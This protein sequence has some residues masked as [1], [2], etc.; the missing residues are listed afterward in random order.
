VA[1]RG[2]RH[3][4]D[5]RRTGVVEDR[6]DQPP[7]DAAAHPVGV[8]GE[9]LQVEVAVDPADEREPGRGL[10]LDQHHV[11]V[12]DPLDHGRA[13]RE[14][15]AHLL[16]QLVGGELH[17]H[18]AGEIGRFSPSHHADTISR[19]RDEPPPDIRVDDRRLGCA[20]P[21]PPPPSCP[22]TSARGGGHAGLEVAQRS[23][24][25]SSPTV[26]PGS[27]P[28]RRT[29]SSTPGVNAARFIVSWRIV[30]V[31]PPPP[32][33][34]SW[35]AISPDS[36]T[37]WTCTPSTSAPRAPSSW[38]LVASGIAPAPA[39]A[40]ASATSSA[41]RRAVPEGA[42]ALFGWCSSMIS[43]DSK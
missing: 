12:G 17:G 28:T 42:S 21:G 43:T 14:R 37:E 35:W 18:Q 29:P 2:Q 4:R 41:V 15:D 1:V 8:D 25:R 10:A 7:A 32:S 13:G 36:R 40:R 6:L 3:R 5:A 31:S 11:R 22:P 26:S 20:A 19:W 39:L 27:S 23:S 38:E 16:E 34:T 24:R 33:S 9:L 30:R